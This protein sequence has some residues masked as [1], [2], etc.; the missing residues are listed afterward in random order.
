M[1]LNKEK[2]V[3]NRTMDEA[4][5]FIDGLLAV[6][7]HYMYSDEC[8]GGYGGGCFSDP[9]KEV[10]ETMQDNDLTAYIEFD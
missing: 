9:Q 3:R 4:C 6:I 7:K 2:F 1:R 5:V 8:S 10:K